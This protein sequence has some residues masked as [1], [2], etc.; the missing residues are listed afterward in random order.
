MGLASLFYNIKLFNAD[1][2]VEKGDITSAE[3]KYLDIWY[4]HEDAPAHLAAMYLK[5]A[6]SSSSYFTYYSKAVNLKADGLEETAAAKLNAVKAS[7]VN[8]VYERASNNFH[9]KHYDEAIKFIDVIVPTGQFYKGLSLQYR[10]HRLCTR[11]LKDKSKGDSDELKYY[12]ES[13]KVA[14]TKFVLEFANSVLPAYANAVDILAFIIDDKEARNLFDKIIVEQYNSINSIL[15][16]QGDMMEK[17][18][19]C[20]E[21]YADKLKDSEYK[22][23]CGLYQAILKEKESS[24][25]WE[26]EEDEEFHIA[27][28]MLCDN[29]YNG[30][31][32]IYNSL[33]A[34]TSVTRLYR[35]RKIVEY[36]KAAFSF[37]DGKLN[38]DALD[39]YQWSEL[40]RVSKELESD[41]RNDV[42]SLI[43]KLEGM[44]KY[45]ESL[46]L[47]AVLTQDNVTL[48]IVKTNIRNQV[49]KGAVTALD[50][51]YPC[52]EV[53]KSIA[54][55][56]M[57]F[58]KMV[59]NN[60]HNYRVALAACITAAPYVS[61]KKGFFT[62][63]AETE[64]LEAT[65]VLEENEYQIFRKFQL[66]LNSYNELD[67]EYIN[68]LERRYNNVAY[69]YLSN[70]LTNVPQFTE[71]EWAE[72]EM[73]IGM[74]STT[75]R[76]EIIALAD[77][78]T[79][80]RRYC[81]SNRICALLEQEEDLL[82]I[83][84]ENAVG[85][86]KQNNYDSLTAIYPR[87]E[88][89]QAIAD[90]LFT[91]AKEIISNSKL[92]KV[93]SICSIIENEVTDKKGYYMFLA[94]VRL[95][96]A[97]LKKQAAEDLSDIV[98][99]LS[100]AIL[101]EE[102][103]TTILDKAENT[104]DTFIKKNDHKKVYEMSMSFRG[105]RTSFSNAFLDAS[106]ALSKTP[107]TISL[108]SLDILTDEIEKQDDPVL[109]Y[110]RFMENFKEFVPKFY[111]GTYERM[112]NKFKAN[113]SSACEFFHS[114]SG[115]DKK[116]TILKMASKKDKN[117][118]K[119]LILSILSFKHQESLNRATIFAIV[120]MLS[121][122]KDYEF[123]I[124]CLRSL[125]VNKLG[126]EDEYVN[127]VI[128]SI[129]E[130]VPEQQLEAVNDA[131]LVS[132]S[133][134]LTDKKKDIAKIF[135]EDS[136]DRTID[137]CKEMKQDVEVKTILARA[138]VS[139]VNQ[140]SSLLE[141]LENLRNAKSVC[142]DDSK[143]LM[144]VICS[145]A[146]RLA[147][148]F[149][150]TGSQEEAY[151]LFDEFPCSEGM[152]VFLRHRVKDSKSLTS[153]AAACSVLQ[154]AIQK[155]D[156]SSFANEV[157]DSP[158]Y[159]QAWTELILRSVAKSDKQNRTSSI[160]ALEN[161]LSQASQS[162]QTA[163]ASSG[164][165]LTSL[166]HDKS[167][168][169]ARELEAAGDFVGAISYYSKSLPDS[170]A[171]GR[172][173]VCYIKRED[174]S[175]SDL[176]NTV[177]STI[178]R[179]SDRIA[180]DITYRYVLRLLKAGDVSEAISFI[181]NRQVDAE[182]RQLCEYYRLKMIRSDIEAFNSKVE[183]MQ[184]GTMSLDEAHAFQDDIEDLA[185]PFLTTYPELRNSVE[186]IKEA[187][188]AYILQ[189]AFRESKFEEAYAILKA[190]SK[191]YLSNKKR[192]R[193]LASAALG[194]I[195]NNK[196]TTQ[197]YKGVIAIFLTAAFNDRMIVQSIDD[198]TWD[199]GYSFTLQ[200]ALGHTK[201]SDLHDIPDNVNDYFPDGN[202]VG[203][204]QVQKSLLERAEAAL[205][206]DTK[207]QYD[208][209]LKQKEAM[210]AF[211]ELN[212]YDN[213]DV[214]A[215]F[216]LESLPASYTKSFKEHLDEEYDDDLKVGCL[217]GFT[218]GRY[219]TYADAEAKY[220]ECITAVES[221]NMT[222][223]K[224][225]FNESA[226]DLIHE[227]TELSSK[228]SDKSFELFTKKISD[229][230]DYIMLAQK[231]EFICRAVGND[232]LSYK[233]S[234]YINGQIIPKLNNK[235]IGMTEGI[236]YLVMA[237]GVCK[238]NT[239]LNQNIDSILSSLVS[240]YIISGNG[241]ITEIKA[242]CSS[243]KDRLGSLV[244]TLGED[245]LIALIVMTGQYDRL[246]TV[247]E[248]L[249]DFITVSSSKVNSI[250]KKMD[251]LKVKKELN[252][253]IGA[254]NE[255]RL[256]PNS[257]RQK[258]SVMYNV[259]PGDTHLAEN[260]ATV[261]QMA[262]EGGS[263]DRTA[264]IAEI[265]RIYER[266]SSSESIQE[267]F[268]TM[269]LSNSKAGVI[270]PFEAFN[271]TKAIYDAHQNNQEVC[272]LF[273]AAIINSIIEYIPKGG[274]TASSLKSTLDS[275]YYKSS[276]FSTTKSQFR[277]V[278]NQLKSQFDTK[279][280]QLLGIYEESPFCVRVAR[281]YPYDPGPSQTLTEE[282]KRMKEMFSY[283]KKFM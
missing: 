89:H 21:E 174:V 193:N 176:K 141:K 46:R 222:D 77:K 134:R 207:T 281:L 69:H 112:V 137:I 65:R 93:I 237:Y 277:T 12:I 34:N 244:D 264:A 166:I 250:I 265:K 233:F 164:I 199:D 6:K 171:L 155:V 33:V 17:Q 9:Q 232:K 213:F 120:S 2:K 145:S 182:L 67:K 245:Q 75:L 133:K 111:E 42:L 205:S 163:L 45:T 123:T 13:C 71:S 152:I 8:Y 126:G 149:F 228:L 41:S 4:K 183:A 58:A 219:G 19:V 61:D 268:A 138:Y 76:V 3:K 262:A 266:H 282:G 68:T 64:L 283:L 29:D 113:A 243:C 99:I 215:P 39:D 54:E 79:K 162:C 74:V 100:L 36:N 179:T 146:A 95:A 167:M 225:A 203:I 121:E 217:Y 269:Y 172:I 28:E 188:P 218:E 272:Q 185:R 239:Q 94:K 173:A 280:Q 117:L 84:K 224:S 236:K 38:H 27:E 132:E 256:T 26:K 190:G 85:C 110:E 90:S 106:Y 97:S 78:L 98:R 87:K 254:V 275:L 202:I 206:K 11:F 187:F 156:G 129:G 255:K 259:N 246:R 153:E 83:I 73:V 242:T 119:E 20:L 23:K 150:S 169:E 103:R 24:T 267:T 210:A 248:M 278:Y 148:S 209:Y 235:S 80:E 223:I 230:N 25:L 252:D 40:E 258:I 226:I 276:A 44:G 196:L 50:A 143:G 135:I 197:N 7:L 180:Q 157:R 10:I 238:Q 15:K 16:L 139:S 165:D 154:E 175:I 107:R 273:A 177:E 30:F 124:P 49:R 204:G 261:C 55:D 270:S 257:A 31:K 247:L 181:R 170:I 53:Y 192:F 18:L 194:M 229:G 200:D 14:S 227:F 214:I 5:K 105:Y 70:R 88:L 140:T 116:L 128:D 274:N 189:A 1:K 32:K 48:S 234:D 216:L 22:Q 198:T 56:L 161:I 104:L 66:K 142:P 208:F 212:K 131:L 43:A 81:D 86:V 168:D 159:I 211:A 271:G 186:D 122:S 96:H 201:V 160:E 130:K 158:E 151:Q 184:K 47:V 109:E 241:T 115:T 92:A 231:F 63:K 221:M 52:R 240:D 57:D 51:L 118:F 114:L 60:E 82:G 125:A 59:S 147:C 144:S 37:F 249:V 91:L 191:D 279:A 251:E 35:D 136:P 195:E 260:Y 263:Y 127:A 178:D 102:D 108:V 62:F 220:N 72:I 101:G 253:I